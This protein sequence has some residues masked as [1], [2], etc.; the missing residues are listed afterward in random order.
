MVSMTGF[1]GLC[2][3]IS[4]FTLGS[5]GKGTLIFMTSIGVLLNSNSL[6]TFMDVTVGVITLDSSRQVISGAMDFHKSPALA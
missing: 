6:C 4:R 3:L 5:R 2:S 1:V